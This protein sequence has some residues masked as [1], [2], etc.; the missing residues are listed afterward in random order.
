MKAQ[1]LYG[2]IVGTVQD[3]TGA[4]VPNANVSAINTGTGQTHT[5]ST[6]SG[7][8][9]SL[10]NLIEG[11]YDLTVTATG[12]R[13]LTRKGVT[14]TL[15]TVRREDVAL[16][17]G[18]VSEGITVQASA[19]ELTT[20]KTDVHTDLGAEIV[21]NLPLPHYRNYQTLI[22]LVPGATPGVLQNSIQVSPERALSTNINGVNRNNNGTR[23][24][25]AL[26]IYLWVACLMAMVLATILLGRAW[27]KWLDHARSQPS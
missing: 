12:F 21:Q 1:V 6:G 7:G 8:V 4:V 15:N 2:S 19:Q 17:L 14:V 9:Y 13:S 5:G 18:Q 26:S 20:D 16:E 24:D 22:N 23:I 25:G 3:A 11:S 10:P 27:T